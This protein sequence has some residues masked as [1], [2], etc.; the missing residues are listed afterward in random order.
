M[1]I[2]MIW[3]GN[4][5]VSHIYRGSTELKAVYRGSIKIWEPPFCN[6][7][8][9]Q[10]QPV[11]RLSVNGDA[12]T[13]DLN[14]EY[15]VPITFE[16]P[17]WVR[18]GTSEQEFLDALKDPR[19]PSQVL[20]QCPIQVLENA[21][22]S[23]RSGNIRIKNSATNEYLKTILINQSAGL[24]W[25]T[26]SCTCTVTPTTYESTY[27]DSTLL[28]TIKVDVVSY[29]SQI[30]STGGSRQLNIIPTATISNRN[31]VTSVGF[32]HQ[33]GNTYEMTIRYKRNVTGSS[34]ITITTS[35]GNF[36]DTATFTV[37][38]SQ[39]ITNK[40]MTLIFNNTRTVYKVYLFSENPTNV[41]LSTSNLKVWSVSN[42]RATITWTD[43][44]LTVN[45]GTGTET[46]IREG[47]TLYI[48]Y[49][50]VTD[51]TTLAQCVASS[52]RPMLQAGS[53]V[54]IT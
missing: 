35:N 24:T 48:Y 8:D 30:S 11:A 17:S 42:N 19:T 16:C 50:T 28:H 45:S 32:V 3:N 41:F 21:D 2:N 15:N 25:T 13:L 34:R 46:T 23:L 51:P 1:F 29:A 12:Q 5:I 47:S 33:N 52:F 27:L 54:E 9:T 26:Q 22:G 38:I 7:T 20:L 37:S 36:S 6:L 39:A 18:I 10:Y 31:I 40:T 44:S 49:S 14:A 43:T 53:T 4:D